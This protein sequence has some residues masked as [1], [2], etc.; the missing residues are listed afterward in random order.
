MKL[1][2]ALLALALLL[3]A[4]PVAADE[5]DGWWETTAYTCPPHCGLTASGT[6]VGYGSVAAPWWV[7]FGTPV[8]ID[9]W[10][11]GTV[12]DRGGDIV[13]NRLDIFLPTYGEAIQWGRRSVY[14][15]FGWPEE[16]SEE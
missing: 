7:P 2:A 3:L 6:Q 12:Q 16:V 1:R 8:L 13:G 5:R 9:G 11:V 14:V 4:R 15:T 10:Y